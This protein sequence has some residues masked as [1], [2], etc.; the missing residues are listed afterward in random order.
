MKSNLILF[1]LFY[2]NL[3]TLFAQ[4]F[5]RVENTIGLGVLEE[6]N[7]VAVADYDGDLDLDLFVVAK[8]KDKNNEDKSH[9][10]LFRNN[11]NGTFS[12][13][14]VESGLMNLFPE[15]FESEK[16][17]GLEGFKIGAHWGDYD[18]DGFPDIFFTHIY[19]VQL[20]HNEGDGTFLEV[21]KDAGFEIQNY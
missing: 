19:R 9:S 2:F 10:R 13:V 5:E 12:D 3:N 8:R 6:N 20:F 1:L 21:T 16:F 4:N 14:T 7:G 11:N 17:V 18:N 15:E